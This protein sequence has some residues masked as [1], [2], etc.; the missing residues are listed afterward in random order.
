VLWNPPL[1]PGG[2]IHDSPQAR[3]GPP[4]RGTPWSRTLAQRTLALFGWRVT[5]VMP[6]AP[7]FLLIVAP[8]TSNWD[9]PL[10][11]LTIFATGL[12]INWLGKHSIFFFPAS[13]ILRWLGGEPIDRNVR[14]G[15]VEQSIARFTR[16]EQYILGISPEGTRRAAAE[17]RTGF[18][19]IAVGAG[20]PIVP[21]ALDYRRKVIDFMPSVVPTGDMEAD[22][23]AY[24]RLFDAGMAKRPAQ[25]IETVQA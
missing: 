24:R 25:F 20:V 2:T 22:I 5:G 4:R 18:H 9:F 13:L 12:R 19:R 16:S 21:A 1:T 8:H 14:A 6:T 10:A 23:A 7:R 17:W 11:M 15:T 3:L